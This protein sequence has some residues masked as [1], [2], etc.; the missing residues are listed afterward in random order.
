[1]TEHRAKTKV[2]AA[3]HHFLVL[4]LRPIKISTSLVFERE[5]ARK[6]HSERSS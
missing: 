3:I 1:M 4:K 2:F 6:I 5:I